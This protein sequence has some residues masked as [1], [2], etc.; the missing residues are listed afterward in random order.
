MMF[1]FQIPFPRYFRRQADNGRLAAQLNAALHKHLDDS[2]AL[3]SRVADM[4][5][6]VSMSA[7]FK[8]G[9]NREA[10]KHQLPPLH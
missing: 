9:Y 10:R 4:T 8:E 1:G 3:E 5:R 6:N 7:Q 2:E